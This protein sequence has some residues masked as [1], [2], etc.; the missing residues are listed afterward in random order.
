MNLL[1]LEYFYFVAKEGGFTKASQA[2]RIQQPAISRMVKQL[3]DSMGFALFERVGRNVQL[4]ERGRDVFVRSRRIFE[5]VENLKNSVQQLAGV[6]GGPLSFGATEPI[7]SHFVPAVLQPLLKESPTLYPLIYSAPASVLVDKIKKG[8]LEFG[9]FFHSPHLPAQLKVK[10]LKKVRFFL[11]VKKGL[12]KNK[13]VLESFIGSREIDDSTTQTFPTLDKLKKIYPKAAIKISSNNLTTHRSLVLR[14][15]GVSVLPDFLVG[16]DIR[17]GRLEDVFPR[18]RLEF[19][20][21]VVTRETSVQSLT[22]QL[23]LS[24]CEKI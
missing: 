15:A 16:E 11:V 10:I 20:L 17:A 14:G 22:S 8:E 9:L 12:K 19:D 18:E 3:E 1:H 2:L 24:H 23:F 21:K 7:A 5:D 4:T 13:A 6:P